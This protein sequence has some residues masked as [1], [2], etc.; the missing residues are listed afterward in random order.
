VA[1]GERTRFAGMD[2]G[3]ER[4]RTMTSAISIAP[5]VTVW[6]RPHA[7]LSTTYN[8]LRDPNART[9]LRENDSTGAFRLPRRLGNT[10]S[11]STGATLDLGR[12]VQIHSADSSRVRRIGRAFQPID[13]N[14]SRTLT[15]NFDNTPFTPGLGYQLGLGGL[16]SFREVDGQLATSAGNTA[17]LTATSTLSLPFSLSLATRVERATTQNFTRRVLTNTHALSEGEQL[18]YPDLSLRWNYRPAWL[19]KI[20]SNVGA[21]ARL[22]NQRQLTRAPT[23]EGVAAD[24][25]ITITRS[26]PVSGSIAWTFGGGFATSG[27]YNLSLRRDEQ[28]G[29]ASEGTTR[30]L[31]FDVSKPFR[32]P[33]R[34]NL[35]GQ[36]RTRMSYQQSGSQNV[37]FSPG[38][39]AVDAEPGAPAPLNRTVQSD[40]GRRVINFNADA[41]LAETL[42]FSITG[43]HVVNFNRNFNQRFSQTVFSAVLQW[44]FF[45]G[46]LR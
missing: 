43:S 31:S 8:M 39:A 6:F 21:N 40:Q 30:E 25:R 18:T 12:A 34:W 15:S 27:G 11:F 19:S 28:P 42:S 32:P 14:Y 41:D 26:Y 2:L 38:V 46:E 4:E 17:R 20:I 37:I 7:E 16:D 29:A 24:E 45:S 44:Q 1:A 5:P 13:V 36:I 10:Q 23:E 22:L 3:L 33:Q 9:L 35:R